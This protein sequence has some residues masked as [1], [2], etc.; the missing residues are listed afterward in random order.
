MRQRSM[1]RTREKLEKLKA[2]VTSGRIKDRDKII[3][4]AERILGKN[5]GQRYYAYDLNADGKFEFSMCKSLSHETRIEGKYVIAIAEKSLAVLEAVAIYKDLADV[6]R[7]FRQLKDVWPC[8]RSTINLSLRWH[9]WLS[10]SSTGDSER[11]ASSF[12][13]SARWKLCPRCAMSR[14]E[15]RTRITR[16][17]VAGGS[18]D[19]RRVLNALKI[20]DLRPP[21]PPNK[22]AD[23]A[24]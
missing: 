21:T 1:D 10:D 18:P 20:G 16:C 4:A 9:C 5:H 2:R 17:E 12:P 19:A 6:E 13:R 8:G 23:T 7:G 22:S 14:F 24:M 15:C 3:K 11:L